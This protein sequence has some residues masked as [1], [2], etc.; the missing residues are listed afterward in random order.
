MFF[1][2]LKEINKIICRTSCAIFVLPPETKLPL[3]NAIYL[4][5]DPNKKTATIT[6][7]QIR[8]LLTLAQTRETRERFFVIA[9]AEAMNLAA[10][11]AFL[12]TFEEPKMHHHFVLLTE[13][14]NLLL[15]TILSRA[16][17][18]YL[19]KTSPLDEPPQASPKVLATAKKLIATSPAKLPALAIELTKSKSTTR[20]QILTI[21]ACAIDLLYKSYLKTEN[22][23]F[24]SNLDHYLLLYDNLK[25]NGHLKL[26]LVADLC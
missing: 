9:P 8:E 2:S 25:Q 17:I 18:F 19:Q 13:Y 23:K 12:K 5:P 16:Q 6:I 3:K 1:D 10:Q 7:E 24:L 21:V 20:E 22:P 15:P 14:P 11:N 4:Q 26:H